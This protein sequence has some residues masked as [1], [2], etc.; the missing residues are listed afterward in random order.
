M[1][2]AIISNVVNTEPNNLAET[3]TIY[4]TLNAEKGL[5]IKTKI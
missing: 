5:V 1:R 4:Y 3:Q 2:H